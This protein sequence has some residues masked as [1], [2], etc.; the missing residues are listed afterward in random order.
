MFMITAPIA[1]DLAAMIE[2][3]RQRYDPLV[4][5]M[6][7]H[8]SILKPF[9]YFGSLDELDD[10]LEDIGESVAP[11]KVSIIGWDTYDQI[12]FQLRLPLVAG[13][14]EFATL[15]Q[16]L[17]TGPLANITQ[18]DE[19]YWPNIVFGRFRNQAE[20][21]AA[22]VVLSNF[23]PK[24]VFRVNHIELLQRDPQV[25]AWKL[26]KKFGL[27]ATASGAHRRKR[28]ISNSNLLQN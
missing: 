13:R 8:I 6:P 16:D 7:P 4:S 14:Q 25:A 21:E 5:A 26:E 15:R 11:I 22:I 9:E 24:F 18:P 19:D 10:H 1:E 28:T 2:P 20:L 17:L 27:N 3:Y 23:E 12:G